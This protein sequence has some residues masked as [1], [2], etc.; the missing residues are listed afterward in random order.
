MPTRLPY[1]TKNPTGHSWFCDICR[2]TYESKIVASECEDRCR[3]KAIADK[4]IADGNIAGGRDHLDHEENTTDVIRREVDAGEPLVD[5]LDCLADLV[6][7]MSSDRARWQC[8]CECLTLVRNHIAELKAKCATIDVLRQQLAVADDAFL[9]QETRLG[10]LT[11]PILTSGDP[12]D[13]A[14]EAMEPKK[15]GAS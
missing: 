9:L 8:G 12:V 5:P 13:A 15:A 2:T 14:I 7:K 11:P 3:E 10:N 4:A 1:H 6:G